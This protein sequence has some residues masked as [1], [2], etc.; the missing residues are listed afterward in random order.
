MG[1]D[2]VCNSDHDPTAICRQRLLC[3]SRASSAYRSARFVR[4]NPGIAGRETREIRDL[5]QAIKGKTKVAGG[6]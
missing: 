5:D 1:K 3:R 6:S 2:P 4:G